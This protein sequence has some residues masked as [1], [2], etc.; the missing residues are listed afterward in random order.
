M[1]TLATRRGRM[2]ISVVDGPPPVLRVVARGYVG[3]A[4]IRQDLEHAAAF[5]RDH[6]EGW[7]YLVDPTDVVPNPVNIVYLKAI[8]RLPNVRGYLVVARRRPMRIM[9]R[10]LSRFGGPDRVFASEA[11]ALAYATQGIGA[12]G[13]NPLG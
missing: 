3:P 6:P 9:G 2:D 8:S 5:G 7:V 11:D 13:T 10:L 4:L 1:A 12:A